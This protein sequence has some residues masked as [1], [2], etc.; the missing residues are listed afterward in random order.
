M[1]TARD[2]CNLGEHLRLSHLFAGLLLVSACGIESETTDN[3]QASV[4]ASDLPRPGLYQVTTASQ[5]TGAALGIAGDTQTLQR[6][7]AALSE[8]TLLEAT[9]V[10]CTP[11]NVRLEDG[12]INASMRCTAP[13]TALQDVSRDVRGTYDADSAEVTSDLVLPDGMIRQTTSLERIGDC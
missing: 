5:I 13:G 11:E 7:Y 10:N 9:G 2:Q 1:I 6:C 8:R 12:L 3:N 4:A